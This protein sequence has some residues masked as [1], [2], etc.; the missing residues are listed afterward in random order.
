MD[1]KTKEIKLAPIRVQFP[2]LDVKFW[3]NE[4]LRKIGSILGIP[5]KTDNTQ[6][7]NP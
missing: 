3:G 4:S 2:D 6:E 5:L 1:L 7:I